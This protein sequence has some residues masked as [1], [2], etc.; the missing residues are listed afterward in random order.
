LIFNSLIS[1]K[2]LHPTHNKHIKVHQTPMKAVEHNST[3]KIGKE[4]IDHCHVRRK[5]IFL[6]IIKSSNNKT[7]IFQSKWFKPIVI[8]S[9]II[10][11]V[12]ILVLVIAL[13]ITL[14]S[15]TTTSTV[16]QTSSRNPSTVSVTSSTSSST[17]SVTS[18]AGK[19]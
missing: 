3:I 12:V 9:S 5:D 17:V 4:I 13:S 10:L 8:A 18:S 19:K 16:Q 15:K 11:G 14:T 6:L 7:S 1:H 2:I